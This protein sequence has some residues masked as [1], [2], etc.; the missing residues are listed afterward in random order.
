LKNNNCTPVFINTRQHQRFVEFSDSCR[1][2][3]YIGVCTGRSGV[4][5]TRSAEAYC[6]WDVVEPLLQEPRHRNVVPPKLEGYRAALYTPDVSCT[7]KRLESAIAILRNRFDKLVE[8]SLCWHSPETWYK[9]QQRRFLE[10]LVIDK[11]HR[12]SFRCLEAL[13]DFAEKNKL[14]T[15]LIGMPGF[16]RRIRNYEQINNRVGFYHH[17]NTPRTDELRAIV[18]AR[19]HA[20]QV[21]IEDS[22]VEMLEKVTSSNI[23]KLVNIN[24]EMSR[25]CELNSVTIITADLVE[26]A[27]KTLLLDTANSVSGQP[28]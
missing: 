15:V 6:H 10:L 3:R 9:T 8:D 17:F 1:L 12:L 14:G 5:K 19:W 16:D 22:A 23:R 11:A 18:E 13:N 26:L 4:G 21:T 7:V 24:A 20:P 2:N 27:A 28:K 25:V